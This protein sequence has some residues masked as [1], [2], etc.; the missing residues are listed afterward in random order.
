MRTMAM[1]AAGLICSAAM[2]D[3]T[4]TLGLTGVQLR[5]A[6][7]QTRSSNPDT[8]DAGCSYHYTIDAM[9]RGR[10]TF[11]ILSILFPQATPL[12]QIMETLAPGSSDMLTGDVLSP[13]GGTHPVTLMHQVINGQQ[14]VLGTTITVAA[15]LDVSIDAGNFVTFS[16]TGVTIDPAGTV[17]YLEFTS[18]TATVASRGGCPS[19]FNADCFVDFFDYDDYVNC[20]ENGRCPPGKTADFNGD[21]FADF[22]DYADFVAAFESGC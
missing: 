22:F 13:N 17:G 7:N 18:G 4:A 8:I 1:M 11:S 14:V 5:N 20:F 19:D 10:G 2:A 15:T 16:I 6:T 3:N 21:G 12:A 9:A